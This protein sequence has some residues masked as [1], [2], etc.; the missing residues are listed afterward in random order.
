MNL[1]PQVVSYQPLNLQP[2]RQQGLLPIDYADGD[3]YR[4]VAAGLARLAD[5]EAEK[6]QQDA[7]YQASI[8]GPQAAIAGQPTPATITGG[9]LPAVTSQDGVKVQVAPAAIRGAITAAATKYGEDA[10]TLAE[11]ARIESGYNP[12]A[13]NPGSSAGGLFQFTNGTAKQYGLTNKFD[14]AQSADAA[15]RLLRDNRAFLKNALGRNPTAGELYLAHQQGAAGAVALLRDPTADAAS[16]VGQEAITKNGGHPGMTAGQ[17]ATLW[18]SKV[19]PANASSVT[20]GAGLDGP[21]RAVPVMDERTPLQITAGK[22][23]TFRP[24]PGN[25]IYARTY[26]VTGMR[27][28]LQLLK[29]DMLDEQSQ[30]YD[31]YKDDPVKLKA[32]YDQLLQSNKAE[33]NFLPEIAPEYELSFK[34]NA[35]DFVR[36]A[37]SQQIK[38][39]N[40]QDLADY[41]DR[42]S[43]AEDRKSQLLAGLDPKDPQTL[44]MLQDQQNLIDSHYDSALARGLMSPLEVQEAKA[45]SKAQ[46]VVP[47]YLKQAQGLSAGDLDALHQ[48]M[49][50]DYAAANLPNVTAEDWQNIDQGLTAASAARRSL[51]DKADDDLKSRGN[52]LATNILH[53][54]TPLASD[55]ARMRVDARTAPHGDE[56]I[57][58]TDA[59][60]RLMNA[61]RTQP[62][63]QVEANLDTILKGNRDTVPSDDLT[64]ARTQIDQVRKDLTTDPL[65]VAEK[66]GLVQAVPPIALD[67]LTDPAKLRD[68]LAY[69]RGAAIMAAQH[70]GVPVKYFRPGEAGQIVNQAMTNPDSMVAFTLNVSRAFGKDTPDAMREIS[71][72]GPV[73]AH[74]VGAAISTGD[75]SLARDVATIWSMKKNGQLDLKMPDDGRLG[76][77]GNTY[78]AGALF[79]QPK[80]Q[81]AALQTANLLFEKA[82][83]DQGFD[84]K[85]IN[86]PK[87]PAS[88]AYFKALDRALGGQVL[89]GVDTG[90]IGLV[91][92]RNIIVPAL[93]PKDRPD[94]LIG[95][96]SDAQLKQLPPIGSINKV[97]IT[98]SAIRDGYLISAGDGLYRVTLNDPQGDQPDYVVAPNGKP[99]VLD[100]RQLDK[101]TRTTPGYRSDFRYPRMGGQQ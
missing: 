29:T 13:Q 50:A 86:D 27:T 17:F 76:I 51:D 64:F 18:T 34:Q 2:V 3:L 45:K 78:L 82:A 56:I 21:V 91:N 87:S 79:L 94:Q 98:A 25:S 54:D 49:T 31:K 44:P 58:S 83:A 10:G 85:Q 65:G 81:N 92:G 62:V 53:G 32:A 59:K 67:G 12:N 90:G 14:V 41:K 75:A 61:L 57:A 55:L 16:I 30:L 68:A 8:A 39:Q 63:G 69:R 36:Q 26:N 101:L 73:M 74:A 77:A 88:A 97:P 33:Q 35:G 100:I 60:I 19:H 48:K 28:Y 47:F 24:M 5:T 1:N 38:L 93:M 80:T 71:D 11:F 95:G 84:P 70:F 6:Y 42:I 72:A 43:G 20:P 4:R 37:Q 9:D 46:M 15:A 40:E 7:Q 89:N 96:L 99:W 66:F 23:G 22:A 52:L